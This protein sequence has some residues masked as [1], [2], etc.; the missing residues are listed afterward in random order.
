MTKVIKVFEGKFMPVY[1]N[2]C[3]AGN[4]IGVLPKGTHDNKKRVVLCDVIKDFFGLWIE[5][6]SEHKLIGKRVKITVEVNLDE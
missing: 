1:Y 2:E 4:P 3:E 5:D 6:F